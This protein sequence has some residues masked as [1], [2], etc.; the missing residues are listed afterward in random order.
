[1]VFELKP[2]SGGN[3]TESVLH[4]FKSGT[5]GSSPVAALVFDGTGKLYG[6]T[7]NG[8]KYGGGTVFRLKSTNSGWTETLL[9]SF[10][11]DPAC[12]DGGYPTDRLLF[13]TAGNIYGTTYFGGDDREYG[14]VFRLAPSEGGWSEIVL[15]SFTLRDGGQ[16]WAGLTADASGTLYGTTTEGGTGGGCMYSCG[17]IFKVAP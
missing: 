10:C 12:R 1:V 14:T 11:H 9:Y 2:A 4:V 5:D 17:T 16:P 15:H 13:D 7:P 8:G 3:W 6:T